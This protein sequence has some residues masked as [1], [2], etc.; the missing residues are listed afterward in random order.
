MS[1]KKNINNI[2]KNYLLDLNSKLKFQLLSPE[3]FPKIPIKK[4]F[5]DCLSL[6]ENN[7][8]KKSNHKNNKDKLIPKKKVIHYIN[9]LLIKI[10]TIYI[11]NFAVKLKI[12]K[13]EF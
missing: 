12:K 1:S 3:F 9:I 13:R 6:K 5:L 10:K 2:S 7:N 8:L 11:S 4:I